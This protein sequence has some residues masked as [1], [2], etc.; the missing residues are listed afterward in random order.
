MQMVLGKDFAKR[1][2]SP[3][4][5]EKIKSK[6]CMDLSIETLGMEGGVIRMNIAHYYKY[7]G[8]LIPDPEMV[9]WVY[10]ETGAVKPESYRTANVHQ[11]ATPGSEEEKDQC[12]FLSNWFRNLK[13]QGFRKTR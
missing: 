2:S 13:F 11:I 5:W 1:F 9:I 8:D 10:P 12:D 7:E 4:A 3:D 6:G